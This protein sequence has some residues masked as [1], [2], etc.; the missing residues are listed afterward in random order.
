VTDPSPS[1]N[2]GSWSDGAPPASGHAGQVRSEN[3][4]G[5]ELVY[6]PDRR[7][8]N[9][10]RPPAPASRLM[11]F[12]GLRGM[13]TRGSVYA[14]Y[15]AAFAAIVVGSAVIHSMLAPTRW[16]TAGQWMLLSAA[17]MV[18]TAVAGTMVYTNQRN[19]IIEQARHF[20]FGLALFPG[21]G[22]AVLLRASADFFSGPAAQGDAFASMLGNALPI[23]YFI[24]VLIPPLVFIKT[25][26]GLRNLHRSN[27]DNEEY[28]RLYTRQDELAR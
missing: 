22:F 8:P 12:E 15:F 26:A 1:R 9:T 24:T 13:S 3:P 17:L 21:L 16:Q 23:L 25:I 14:R 20:I 18:L 4:F 5:V 10:G 2:P 19:E 27:L 28:M 6:D 11:Q 7:R